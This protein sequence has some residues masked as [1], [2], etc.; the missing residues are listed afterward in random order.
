M[1]TEAEMRTALHDADTPVLL[2]VLVH[3]TGDERWLEPP[4]SLERT[5]RLIGDETGG[6]SDE[7]RQEIA[8]AVLVAWRDRRDEAQRAPSQE[9]LARMMSS[10]VGED[11]PLE[12][13]PMM[14]ADLGFGSD[15]RL[16]EPPSDIANTN[17]VIIGAGVSG[18][19]LSVELSR[20]GVPHILLEKNESLGGTW[21][22]NTY[23]EAGVD[24]PN[25]FYSYSFAPNADWSRY[26]AK[27]DE[28]L[29][30][31][32]RCADEFKV[33]DHCVFNATV[34]RLEY[35][36]GDGEWAVTYRDAAGRENV[37]RATFAVS[38]VGQVNIPRYPEIAGLEEFEGLVFHT[39]RWPA[40]VE[41][42][43]QRVA[44]IGTGASAVQAA[45]SVAASAE[46]L[47]IYQRSPQ[48][49]MPNPDYHR[50]VSEEKRFLLQHLPRYADWYR[51]GLFW[52][53][54]DGVHASL[55]KD[56]D[57][58]H[59][60][61][62]VNAINDRHRR[63]LTRYIESHLQD[64]PDLKAAAVPDY[65]PYGKRMVM[66]NDWFTTL[67]RENVQLVPHGVEGLTS[68]GVVAADGIERT[69]DVVVLATGFRATE[70]LSGIEI[71]GRDGRTLTET[72]NIDEPLTYLG[73]ATPGFPNF[74]MMLGPT[75]ALAHGG[76]VIFQ[77]ELQAKYISSAMG[78]MVA[79]Q[80][81][82]V[83]CTP[84]AARTY[85]REATDAHRRLVFTHPGMSNWYKN[86][87]G[88]VVTVSPWRLV[89]YRRMMSTMDAGCWEFR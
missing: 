52:R 76:S 73:I 81:T 24:T 77:V 50:L 68:A 45:R 83:E 14:R 4:F 70:M 84:E 66:D 32:E 20:H 47:T 26:F 42:E 60:E 34:E 33:V 9:L 61:R 15:S 89:D 25:H 41:L 78:A 19:C 10:F 51:F 27:A 63:F 18:L 44:M 55:R 28:I 22:E 21:L 12:Y 75:T 67:K 8:D 65:P 57:W 16:P 59:P 48:W 85:T 62:A 38:A 82:S 39:A 86:R 43:G 40:D 69:A 1:V 29:A 56:P 54:A 35:H 80:A 11:V 5:G 79:N 71:R 30:Y 72:W 23:P 3:L 17:V 13:V 87:A 7:L 58:E 88:D 6:L 31:L 53:Y 2:M 49:I 46:E 64:R 37:V 74:F 36:D